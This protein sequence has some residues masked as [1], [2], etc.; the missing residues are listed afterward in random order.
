MNMELGRWSDALLQYDK[1]L[2]LTATPLPGVADLA[3]LIDVLFG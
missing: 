2:G 3:E 1:Y